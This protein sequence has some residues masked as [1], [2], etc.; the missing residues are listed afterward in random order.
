MGKI[1]N[2]DRCLLVKRG[3]YW[4]PNGQGYT[5]FKEDAGVYDLNVERDFGIMTFESQRYPISNQTSYIR[6]NEAPDLAP[7]ATRGVK[8]LRLENNK[9]SKIR[10]LFNT[11]FKSFGFA[12]SLASVMMVLAFV[13]LKFQELNLLDNPP[14]C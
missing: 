13:V 2:K 7:A 1:K 14:F 3:Y 12:M 11:T 4:R 5:I 8:V 10:I 6:Y 9:K